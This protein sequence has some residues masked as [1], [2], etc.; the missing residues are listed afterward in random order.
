MFR[1]ISIKFGLLYFLLFAAKMVTVV[2]DESKIKVLLEQS[3][4]C[5]KLK[6]IVKIG[7]SVTDEEKEAGDKVGIKITCFRE[8]EVST[9]KEEFG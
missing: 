8:L 7:S 6:N 1:N 3:D 2:C 5:P 9:V 4:K